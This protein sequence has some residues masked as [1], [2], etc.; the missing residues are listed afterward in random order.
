MQT[1]PLLMKG[2]AK[3]VSLLGA[4]GACLNTEG[5]LYRATPP[6]CDT[7]PRFL[8]SHPKKR[9]TKSPPILIRIPDSGFGDGYYDMYTFAANISLSFF[10]FTLS[11]K[12]LNSY[13]HVQE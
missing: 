1:S 7:G 5:Y 2:A 3:F 4:S 9:P 13:E 10:K 11:T 6:F 8:R 12:Y